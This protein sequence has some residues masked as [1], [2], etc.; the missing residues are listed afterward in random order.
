MLGAAGLA[1][2][3][4]APAALASVVPCSVSSLVSAITTANNTPGGGTLTL[5]SGC[6]YTLTAENNSADGGTGLPV[7]TGQVTIQGSG[8]T[9]TRS[10]SAAFHLLDVASGGSLAIGGGL[11]NGGGAAA[12]PEPASLALLGLGATGILIRRKRNRKN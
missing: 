11:S 3:T 9:I 5:T 2:V 7:I 8:A 1:G 12:T 6:T 10:G 4:F